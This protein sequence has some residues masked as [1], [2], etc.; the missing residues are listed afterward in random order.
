MHAGWPTKWL[1][2]RQNEK[3]RTRES[4]G[5]RVETGGESG[6]CALFALHQANFLI[7]QRVWL[8]FCCVAASKFWYDLSPH[9]SRLKALAGIC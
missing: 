2:A 3:A 5:L 1:T 6:T 8:N 9:S 7:N 4:A